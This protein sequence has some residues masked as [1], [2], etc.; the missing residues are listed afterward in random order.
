MDSNEEAVPHDRFIRFHRFP[1]NPPHPQGNQASEMVI[2]GKSKEREPQVNTLLCGTSAK[3][4]DHNPLHPPEKLSVPFK[5]LLPTD[6]QNGET[7]CPARSLSPYPLPL[8]VRCLRKIRLEEK[9]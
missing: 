7:S 8:Q 6:T 2:Y 4:A 5:V 3:R 1:Q 9:V